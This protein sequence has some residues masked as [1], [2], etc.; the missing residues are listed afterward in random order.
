MVTSAY[1]R[2]KNDCTLTCH[3]NGSDFRLIRI[4]TSANI[5][6][7]RNGGI[8]F[9]KERALLVTETGSEKDAIAQREYPFPGAVRDLYFNQ[10][11][12]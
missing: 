4:K 12:S 1:E 2:G 5:F 9:S 7:D 3:T 11:T 6:H 10:S 8:D